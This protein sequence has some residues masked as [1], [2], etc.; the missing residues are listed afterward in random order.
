MCHGKEFESH[1]WCG[2]F[3]FERFVPHMMRKVAHHM[4]ESV[5]K[6][7]SWIPYNLEQREDS[8][9]IT[10]PL[11]G[12][13]KEDVSVTLIGNNLNIKAS[14]PK[15][16]D[17]A[18][19]KSKEPKNPFLRYFFTFVDVDMDIP[20]P[21]NADLESI[22]SV[23]ANGLLRVKIGKKPSKTINVNVSEEGIT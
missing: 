13:G 11:P 12:R 20:L 10:V 16:D 17:E 5:G 18:K 2:S 19:E 7:G 22:K 21:Q 8:Y 4:E 15:V 9:L 23:M 1:S 6:A 14:K 3:P